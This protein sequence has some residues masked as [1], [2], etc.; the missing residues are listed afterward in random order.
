MGI[1]GEYGGPSYGLND[2][3]VALW[4]GDDSYGPAVDIPSAQLYEPDVKTN[5]AELEGDDR[6]TAT[7][8]NVISADVR[9][10][11]GSVAM[12]V[13]SLITGNTID[14][15]G[16]TPN[17]MQ[18]L[19]IAASN[20]PYVSICGRAKAEEGIGDLHV[21]IKKCKLMEGF[22][23]TLEYGAFS[24]PE[25]TFKAVADSSDNILH[26]LPHEALTAVAI[27]PVF[28]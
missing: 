23:F 2:L 16:T 14:D 21:W 4:L 17:Q 20:F 6:I 24:V 9:I 18:N 22:K 12:D 10:R 19:S 3:K 5:N 15:Y 26:L 13:I 7:A 11:F 8:A 25:M 28:G 1:F 27:P